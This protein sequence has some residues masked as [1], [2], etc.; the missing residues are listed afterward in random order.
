MKNKIMILF[1]LFAVAALLAGDVETVEESGAFITLT[2]TKL[3]A[4]PSVKSANIKCPNNS[5]ANCKDSA[6][7]GETAV[8][9]KGIYISTVRRT[10]KEEKN[11]GAKGYW[12]QVGNPGDSCAAW[13]FGGLLKKQ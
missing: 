1:S 12:Y 5:V 8:L 9:P 10:T 13:I 7:A 4:E 6:C 2:A 11:S 3:R